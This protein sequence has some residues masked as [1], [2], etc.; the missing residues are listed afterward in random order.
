MVERRKDSKGRV[1][2]EGE[3]ERKQ[4]GYQFRWRTPDGKRHTV[5]AP[6]LKELREKE[7]KVRHDMIEGIRP[8]A[9]RITINDIY[10]LWVPLKKGIKENT[11]RN[12]RYMYELFVQPEFGKS[13]ITEIRKSDS[14]TL[15]WIIKGLKYPR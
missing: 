15:L 11:F 1:L 6:T 13:K 2:K 3:N 4:G 7:E 14:T 8:G 12:Y 9:D 10:A 5:Y